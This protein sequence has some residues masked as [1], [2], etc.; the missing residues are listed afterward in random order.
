M[1][2]VDLRERF[3]GTHLRERTGMKSEI[4]GNANAF[5][6]RFL[7]LMPDI[8]Y[9]Q[10]CTFDGY[11]KCVSVNVPVFFARRVRTGT[12][13]TYPSR[14]RKTWRVH[15]W[16]RTGTFFRSTGTH[17][18]VF[19]VDGYAKLGQFK[20]KAKQRPE[21]LTSGKLPLS[22]MSAYSTW[23]C[24]YVWVDDVIFSFF[25]IFDGYVYG[26]VFGRRVRTGTFFAYPETYPTG[27]LLGMFFGSTGTHRYVF[28][29]PWPKQI[30]RLV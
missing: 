22:T 26:Y 11:A 18:Y 30:Y 25:D 21:Q 16:V 3:T 5:P 13:F 4:Y 7:K 27:T 29:V 12:F 1:D 10:R 19:W 9:I 15:L 28:C 24:G 17:G 8:Y 20:R 14:S 6:P 2:S 23:F